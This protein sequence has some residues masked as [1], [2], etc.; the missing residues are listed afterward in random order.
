MRLIA[1]RVYVA[2]PWSWQARTRRK[3]VELREMGYDCS[4]AWLEEDDA[5]IENQTAGWER[6]R[7]LVDIHQIGM[8]NI[9]IAFTC[10]PGKGP[11]RGGRHVELGLALAWGKR[12]IVVGPRENIFCHLPEVEH[13][14][15]WKECKHALHQA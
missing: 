9:L 5:S 8:A 7:A 10:G 15:T 4:P 2:A 13:Y 3:A 1:P 12:V 11:A 14:K 6:H